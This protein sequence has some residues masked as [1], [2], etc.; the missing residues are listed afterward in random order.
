MT[1]RSVFAQERMLAVAAGA[2][3]SAA[4]SVRDRPIVRVSFGWYP[5]EKE[6]EVA[7]ILDYAGKPLGE[8]I[9]KLPGLISYYSGIDRQHH[10]M[11]NVSLWADL[12]SAE[13]MGKLQAMLDQGAELSKLGVTFVRPIPNCATLWSELPAG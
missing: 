6:A 8:A 2:G 11:V 3:G 13:Q 10:V 1:H 7:A 12:S 5:P 9:K 4:A